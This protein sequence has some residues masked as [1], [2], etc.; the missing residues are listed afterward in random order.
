MT[1]LIAL[2]AP[3]LA[4]AL[5]Y[6]FNLPQ[7]FGAH[8][9]WSQPV[10]LIGFPIGIGIAAGLAWTG[11]GRLTRILLSAGMTGVGF[12]VATVGKARFAASYAEDTFAGQMW[13]FGWIGTCAL[14]AALIASAFWP[15]RNAR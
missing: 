11:I 8:P 13:Y 1:Y 10:I 4:A 14:A 9:W 15:Q 12:A 7:T 6:S 2:I 3:A 5:A